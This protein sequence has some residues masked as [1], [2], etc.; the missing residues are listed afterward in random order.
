MKDFL[1]QG[2]SP[3]GTVKHYQNKTNLSKNF[4]GRIYGIV[5]IDKN[6]VNLN[7]S[8]PFTIPSIASLLAVPN[9]RE[10]PF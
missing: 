6:P 9:M 8:E 2:R 3:D 10:S 4:L 1:R 7:H 5:R